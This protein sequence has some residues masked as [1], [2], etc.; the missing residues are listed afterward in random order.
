MNDSNLHGVPPGRALASDPATSADMLMTLM[1]SPDAE[2]RRLAASNRSCPTT[3]IERVITAGTDVAA[4]CGAAV[5]L[6]TAEHLLRRLSTIMHPSVC[7]ATATNPN[8]PADALKRM[9]GY[10]DA[11]LLGFIRTR[12]AV[13]A[14]PSTPPLTLEVLAA[15]PSHTVQRALAHNPACPTAAL[16]DLAES[17]HAWVRIAAVAH[18]NCDP[19]MLEACMREGLTVRN[20]W[21]ET[22]KAIAR[23]PSTAPW[24]L[25]LLASSTDSEIRCAVATNPKLDVTKLSE[26]AR[27]DPHGPTRQAAEKTLEFTRSMSLG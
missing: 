6:A 26:M 5:N 17:E 22:V 18:P 12:A 21:T 7:E 14:H 19:D 27:H 15:D 2:T 23:N 11:D 4:C 8:T 3:A 25:V 9:A 13:A 16:S 24:D 1:R 10:P 20:E